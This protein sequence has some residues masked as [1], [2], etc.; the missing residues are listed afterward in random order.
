[1]I[2]RTLSNLYGLKPSHLFAN[3]SFLNDFDNIRLS[4][5]HLACITQKLEAVKLFSTKF[6]CNSDFLVG[7]NPLYFACI[8]G[9]LDIVKY[10]I[11][12]HKYNPDLVAFMAVHLYTSQFLVVTWLL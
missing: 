7:L 3:F 5:I 8:M 6:N 11:T 1:M 12:E 2:I 10:L 9:N 4:P